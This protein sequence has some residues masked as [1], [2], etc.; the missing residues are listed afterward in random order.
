MKMMKKMN[1]EK[2]NFCKKKIFMKNHQ[3]EV[4]N[5]CQFGKSCD[6]IYG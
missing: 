5:G 4:C 1:D 3:W 2:L 6:G